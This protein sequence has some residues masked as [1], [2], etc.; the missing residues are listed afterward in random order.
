M[1]SFRDHGYETLTGASYRNNLGWPDG[2]PMVCG[3]T[4]SSSFTGSLVDSF[5]E[6]EEAAREGR[7]Q[8]IKGFGASMQTKV[9]RGIDREGACG[10]CRARRRGR[11]QRKPVAPRS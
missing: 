11:D 4:R 6:L 1:H 8:K 7:L 3:R 2:A 9:L 10:M 5:A